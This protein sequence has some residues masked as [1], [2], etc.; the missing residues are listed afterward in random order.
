MLRRVSFMTLIS[1]PIINVLYY[2]RSSG[3]MFL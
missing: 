3:V 2:A 1:I